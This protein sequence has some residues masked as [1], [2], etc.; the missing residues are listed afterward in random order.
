[1][2][3]LEPSFLLLLVNILKEHTDIFRPEVIDRILKDTASHF[4]TFKHR[5]IDILYY[6]NTVCH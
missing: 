5:Y 6:I 2:Q 4:H 1:V 3:P